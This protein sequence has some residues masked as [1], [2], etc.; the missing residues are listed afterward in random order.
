MYEMP[1][2]IKP[3]PQ[4]EW[5][6]RLQDLLEA[7][8]KIVRQNKEHAMTRQKHYHDKRLNWRFSIHDEV[9]VYFPRNKTGHSPK[10]TSYWR[11]PYQE[12]ARRYIR[13]ELWS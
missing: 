12:D 1:S 6:W 7:A 8:H 13:C 11:G 2:A 10:F 5:V 4:N 9:Y 3:T